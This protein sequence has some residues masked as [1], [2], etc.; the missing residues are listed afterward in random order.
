[1]GSLVAL[2]LA[3]RLGEN[4]TALALIGSGVPMGVSDGLL[5]AARDDTPAAIRMIT[6]WSHAPA[7]LLGGNRTPGLW[8]PGINSALMRR[9]KPGVLHR[10]LLNCREYLRGLDAA[11]AVT[12]PALLVCGERDLMT[13]AKATQGL[14]ESLR[15]LKVVSIAGA[16]HAL[17]GEQPDA[18]LDALRSFIRA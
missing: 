14:R 2:E 6:Q 13:P 11:A 17:M 9:A 1:M 3:S 7:S 12:C 18:V 5:N 8:L 16:G 10:D 15:G 4:A